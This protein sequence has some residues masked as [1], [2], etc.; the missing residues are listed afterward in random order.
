MSRIALKVPATSANLGPGFDSLGLAW[1][2]YNLLEAEWIPGPGWRIQVEGAGA[3]VLPEDSTNIVAQA[4]QRVFD[5]LGFH[6][7]GVLVRLVNHIPLARGLGSS[8][9]ARVA[10][11]AA[12][13]GLAGVEWTAE[14]LLNLAHE[15]E[16]HPDNVVPALL[17][18]FTV[19][20]LT[21][22]R[23][24]YVR[25]DPPADLRAVLAVPEFEL[26]TEQARAVLPTAY[27]RS[28]AVHNIGHAALVVAAIMSG[29][30]HLLREAMEDRIHQPY[31]FPL[32]PGATAALQAAREAGALGV[33]I[34]GAGP[35][36]LALATG[37]TEP[38]VQAI[39]QV[40]QTQGVPHEVHTVEVDRQGL[41]ML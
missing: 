7:P 29:Q 31:R 2:L 24:V 17:G 41:Q 40:W 27:P 11:L 32:I 4:M 6:P 20:A 38:I 34:S 8:A 26:P 5:R 23:V 16:G 21:E 19:A 25:A 28:D 36:L 10:G 30:T 9:A 14:E 1:S 18:G 33:A 22:G 3:G 15:L 35:T 12:A 37:D 39:R 13:Y